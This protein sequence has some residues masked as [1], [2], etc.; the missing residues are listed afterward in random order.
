M[1]TETGRGISRV[2]AWVGLAVLLLVLGY[3]WAQTAAAKDAR[4]Q[5]EAQQSPQ[6]AEAEGAGEAP[7]G[8]AEDDL[9]IP[10]R[11]EPGA[12]P[13]VVGSGWIKYKF[14]SD[15]PIGEEPEVG[16]LR[17]SEDGTTMSWS[18]IT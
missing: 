13:K 6:A 11:P 16:E 10:K 17:I 4:R 14:T 1:R 3:C 8:E 15:E 12:R 9:G 2:S 18:S 5:A 7:E